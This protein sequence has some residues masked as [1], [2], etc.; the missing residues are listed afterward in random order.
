MK[1][2]TDGQLEDL[3]AL[4]KTDTVCAE[5]AQAG[6]GHRFNQTDPLERYLSVLTAKFPNMCRFS[7]TAGRPMVIGTDE[8]GVQEKNKEEMREI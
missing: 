2:F 5:R 6:C 4:C 8:P 1:S 3:E 7:L